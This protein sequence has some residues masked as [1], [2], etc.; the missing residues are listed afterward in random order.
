M[1]QLK[2]E[3][4][5]LRD[6]ILLAKKKVTLMK[7]IIKEEEKRYSFGKIDLEKIIEL[8]NN[9]AQYRANYQ[10][11]LIEL[12]KSYLSWHVLTNN[13]ENIRAQLLESI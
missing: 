13:I 10:S 5:S 11:I 12:N 1:F 4:K 9:Y 3:I 2:A 6:K 7:K 8:K